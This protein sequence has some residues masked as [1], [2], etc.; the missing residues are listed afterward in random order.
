MLPQTGQRIQKFL[1]DYAAKDGWDTMRTERAVNILP[2]VLQ[3]V[4]G[5]ILEI[6]AL[7]GNTTNV[8]CKISAEYDR[9]VHVVDPWDG[10]QQG[11]H[12]T[13]NKFTANTAGNTNLTVQKLGSEDPKVLA[14]FKKNG[15]KFAFI[16][17]DGH[18]TY[19]SVR[20]DITNFK[21]L[22]L[23]NGIIC[24]DDWH[25]PYGFSDAIQKACADHLDDNYQLLES[26]ASL[27]ERY[28]VK[29]S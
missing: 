14:K 26:P 6:G 11:S 13:Y 16:L 4:A 18:H 7:E 27:I 15:T 24:V 8:F 20:S 17:I 2:M 28:F 12:S 23:P 29:L 9:T 21:D 3:H 22:L 25:G 10:R 19:E 1:D 5:D